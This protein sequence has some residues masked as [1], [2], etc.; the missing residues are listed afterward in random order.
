MLTSLA[1]RRLPPSEAKSAKTIVAE[2]GTAATSKAAA[3]TQGWDFVG[4]RQTVRDSGWA[5]LASVGSF[6]GKNNTSFDARNYGLGKLSELVR[7]QPYLEVK[8][9]PDASGFVHLD[10]RVR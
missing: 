2:A 1:A 7:K 10:V 4:I 9:T 5:T 6:I 8:E 3:S